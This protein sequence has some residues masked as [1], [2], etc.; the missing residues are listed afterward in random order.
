MQAKKDTQ[1]QLEI[2]EKHLQEI[3]ERQMQKKS[4]K[5]CKGI[6]G[7]SAKSESSNDQ[8]KELI[9]RAL[10]EYGA[11]KTGKMDFALESAGTF[12]LFVQFK[13]E[14]NRMNFRGLHCSNMGHRRLRSWFK[15]NYFIRF[16]HLSRRK[17]S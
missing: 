15:I 7:G 10:E 16:S 11:D 12:I 13:N 4:N 8:I 3:K 14:S 5:A 17:W 2:I 1:L 6:P 9:R